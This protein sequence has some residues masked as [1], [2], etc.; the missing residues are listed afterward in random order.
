[1]DNGIRFA[2]RLHCAMES[3]GSVVCVGLDPVVEK[4]P[5]GIK[6]RMGET[7]GA[8]DEFCHGVINAVAGRVAAVKFQSACFERLGTIGLEVMHARMAHAANVGLA[9]I[10]DAKRGDIALTAGHYA[11]AAKLSG[12]HAVTLSGYMGVEVAEPFLKQGMGVFLLVRTSNPEG[13]RIQRAKLE[14]GRTVAQMMADET[15]RLGAGWISARGLS[16]VG[17]V[18]GATQASE[19]AELRA[20]MKD[21]VFLIPGYGA[22]GGTKD[23]IRV[24]L[25]S[26]MK[27]GERAGT[28]GV[29]VTSSRAII[30]A[31][32]DPTW[33]SEHAGKHWTE[34]V[35]HAAVKMT[36][37]LREV[38]G[39]G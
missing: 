38:V 8:V 25:R 39:L 26:G 20:R 1:M 37:E 10:L 4:L 3:T 34:A 31:Y 5:A 27:D 29:L 15:A 33:R 35:T 12:A 24:M 21:Q 17:A 14:D 16:D 9:V 2:E 18:V 28:S 13:D 30:Y 19:A 6:E 23:D 36:E 11:A 7:V 32:D 22:Q